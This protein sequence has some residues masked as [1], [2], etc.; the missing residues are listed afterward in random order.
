MFTVGG[1]VFI[2]GGG[3]FTVQWEEHLNLSV[4]DDLIEKKTGPKI[5][6]SVSLKHI[7]CMLFFDQN[8]TWVEPI[9]EYDRY[10]TSTLNG[11]G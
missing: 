2:V 7:N 5:G 6:Q 8:D 1:A 11:A 4:S 3:A 10:D 9:L